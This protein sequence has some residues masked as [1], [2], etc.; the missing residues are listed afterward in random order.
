MKK[1]IRSFFAVFS[2]YSRIPAPFVNMTSEDMSFAVA[3]LPLVGWVIALVMFGWK[4]L[5]DILGFSHIVL[6][7]VLVLIPVLIVGGLHYDGMADVTDAIASCQPRERKIEIMKDSRVGSFAVIRLIFYVALMIAF[8][9]DYFTV[10]S[11]FLLYASLFVVSR[12][13]GSVTALYAPAM[14]KEGF[15][16]NARSASSKYSVIFVILFSI[17]TV[18]VNWKSGWILLTVFVIAAAL[19]GFLTYL[20]AKRHFGG[21]N[22][23]SN[24]FLTQ[25]VELNTLVAIDVTIRIMTCFL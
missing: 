11:N 4:W 24:G 8:T 15:F 18:A 16:E 1:I 17:I 3:F 9:Y 19:T 12:N 6:A 25:M 22:G 20:M 2:T 10:S 21:M 13:V 23:D 5:A 14:A 7:T